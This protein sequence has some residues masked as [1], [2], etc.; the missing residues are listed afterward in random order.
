MNAS[1]PAVMI[2]GTLGPA[3]ADEEILTAMIRNGMT[4]LRFNLSHTTLRALA[5]QIEMVRR[6]EARSASL[7]ASV[8][9]PRAS[10]GAIIA[11]IPSVLRLNALQ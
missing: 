4:G 3:C 2:Y 11:R 8:P 5:P 1:L 9:P 10:A 6:A 7:I